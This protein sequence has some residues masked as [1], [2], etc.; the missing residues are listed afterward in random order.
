MLFKFCS[1]FLNLAEL[2]TSVVLHTSVPFGLQ[3]VEKTIPE[4]EPI[5]ME[6]LKSSF[7]DLPKP[8]ASKCHKWRYSQVLNISHHYFYFVSYLC[9]KII[10]QVTKS[11]EDQ[12]GVLELS[13]E[14]LLLVG[15]DAFTHSNFD[16][17]V[18]SAE[19][20]VQHLAS[21]TAKL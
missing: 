11:Y 16:G 5:L 8:K 6:A 18:S 1:A 7:P 9:D 14:P 10:Y 4:A 15:G 13:Q 3:H 2:P 12:P 21:K 19:K 20:I 17:C